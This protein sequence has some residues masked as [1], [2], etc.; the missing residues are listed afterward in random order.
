MH[1]ADDVGPKYAILR[2][3]R[4]RHRILLVSLL[5]LHSDHVHWVESP[6]HRA[7]L[8][9]FSAFHGLLLEMCEEFHWID[10]A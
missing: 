9:V 7:I 8:H 5:H 6:E 4:T 2:C 10:C 3:D 1:G